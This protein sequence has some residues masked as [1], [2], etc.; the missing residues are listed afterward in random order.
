[1]AAGD[2][3]PSNKKGNALKCQVARELEDFFYQERQDRRVANGKSTIT[4]IKQVQETTVSIKSRQQ[5]SNAV[6]VL[7]CSASVS[8]TKSSESEHSPVR[9]K[10]K[11]QCR[12]GFGMKSTHGEHQPQRGFTLEHQADEHQGQ[13]L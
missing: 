12:T 11:L 10:Q 6:E 5:R 1:M 4:A 8:A 7:I 2:K 9:R 3:K 13:N